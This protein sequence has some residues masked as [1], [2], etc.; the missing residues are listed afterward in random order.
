MRFSRFFL[1]FGLLLST[2][3]AGCISSNQNTSDND[4]LIQRSPSVSESTVNIN[5]VWAEVENQLPKSPNGKNFIFERI[6]TEQG[7][8]QN[9]VRVIT[10]DV[11][12]FLWIGTDYGLNRFD[13]DEFIVSKH[14]PDNPN[15]ISDNHIW[16]IHEDSRNNLWVGTD[17][18]LNLYDR[19]R[20]S[21][22]RF[23]HDESDPWSLSSNRI[24]A[25]LEDSEGNIWIGTWGGGLD[26]FDQ[27]SGEFIH[28]R[29][30]E[31]SIGRI[32]D[33]YIR[34]I[35]E[36][37]R[38]FLWVGTSNGLNRLNP[39]IGEN[40][41]FQR[42]FPNPANIFDYESE[43]IYGGDYDYYWTRRPIPLDSSLP[44]I[45][46]Q[47]LINNQIQAI[48]EDARERKIW[49]GTSGGLD[50]FNLT[51]GSFDH[52]RFDIEDESSLSSNLV[53]SMMIDQT[54][55]LWVGTNNGLNE[56]DDQENRFVRYGY[57][58]RETD[59]TVSL[60][61]PLINTIF[62]DRSG[63]IWVGTSG[64][65]INRFDYS[66]E[67]FTH[68]TYDPEIT[69][70]V[71]GNMVWAFEE[72]SD[73]GYWVGTSVGVDR[74]N[75]LKG[76]FEHF[77][78]SADL[79]N[80]S[81]PVQIFTLHKGF[82]ATIWAGT[83]TGLFKLDQ[84]SKQFVEYQSPK[85]TELKDDDFLS[86]SIILDIAEST[87]GHLLIG[88][89]GSGLISLDINL[90]ITRSFNFNPDDPRGI[91]SNIVSSL[92]VDTRGITYIGTRGGGLNLLYPDSNEF[93]KFSSNPGMANSISD[94]NI[95]QIIQTRDGSIWIAT[96]G[97]LNQFDPA[98]STFLALRE[99]NGLPSNVIYGIA[100]DFQNNLWV[101][102]SNGIA[103]IDQDLKIDAIFQYPHGLQSNE[104]NPGASFVSNDGLIFFGGTKGFSVFRPERISLNPYQPAVILG[105]FTQNR[106]EIDLPASV[107]SKQTIELEWPRNYFEFKVSNFN[108]IQRDK[109]LIAYRLVPLEKDWTIAGS[110]LY[111][112][113]EN[114]GGG[115]YTLEIKGANNDGI[116]GDAIPAMTIEVNPPF[117]EKRNFQ[118]GVGLIFLFLVFGGIQFRIR[119][120]QKY[121]RTL[122]KEVQ[123]RTEDIEKRRKVAE[124]L[125][126]IL[127]RINSDLSLEECLDFVVCQTT[128]LIESPFALMFSMEEG[129]DAKVIAFSLTDPS[130]FDRGI[131]DTL[132]EPVINDWAE[133]ANTTKSVFSDRLNA[134]NGK[135]L[136]DM[137][138]VPILSANTVLGGLAVLENTKIK[139]ND[140][141]L[142][143][144]KSL[145]DQAAL[146]MEN[147]RLRTATEEI[148]VVSERNRI[149][150]DLHDAITQ[151]LFSANLIADS[152]PLTMKN[153]PRK[154]EESLASLQNLNRSALAE[155][156]ALL[157]ELRPAVIKDI[158]LSELL[159]QMADTL[160]GRASVNVTLNLLENF[161]LPEDVHFQFYRIAQ[162]ITT[163]I[164]KH[165]RA[166]NVEI[167][168]V[169]KSYI[170]SNQLFASAKMIIAD[171]GIGFE[172]GKIQG[173]HFGIKDIYE[174]AEMINA[175]AKID[176]EPENGTKIILEWK[177][178]ENQDGGCK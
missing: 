60:N 144:L 129:E 80:G 74:Y 168:F 94:N 44:E 12:G 116:W 34:A 47:Y 164:I 82:D 69:K 48:L 27:Q 140:E 118:L 8:S 127:V 31:T 105:G 46:P 26:R 130:Q 15:S 155:M 148:A 154:G 10:Q 131:V 139:M 89:Y 167:S 106:E 102:T 111:Q 78:V 29:A 173:L 160:K 156:R 101:A 114:L 58:S 107:E 21:F 100:E 137:K 141:D 50:C 125:R 35:Y 165:S 88:T 64:G 162:E 147:A 120:V 135:D 84:E 65:G 138:I 24:R 43:M 70:S 63:A 52:Y 103:K 153:D 124:G 85:E 28:Y 73:I 18:G 19:K 172:I 93:I 123:D 171:D 75:T 151:T 11:Y 163:N 166:K 67:F 177:S 53:L 157:L 1:L 104:F 132:I 66:T 98:T 97:G 39:R 6:T 109:N 113:Y 159:K 77:P 25:I 81:S 40:I 33:N 115:L 72:D 23:F 3:L 57:D 2:F 20:N 32:S 51:T 99:E 158:S 55:T 152:L 71:S 42:D 16:A 7:L 56:F 142:N 87:P 37:S 121:S 119:S 13:G 49:I 112:L 41:I 143:L 79:S 45:E 22:L 54:G 136:F 161:Q 145:A 110:G 146:A 14:D 91:S 59:T 174:R 68:N 90:G 178:K 169:S 126:E 9:T 38:G 95:N 117:W 62:Q 96:M 175:S 92:L 176:S 83:S 4:N 61:H 108:F 17:N 133:K 86:E 134:S 149:A 150:R 170:R 36:D 122:E 30:D 76:A 5:Q 128:R